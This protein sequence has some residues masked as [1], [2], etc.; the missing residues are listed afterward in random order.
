[1]KPVNRRS[2]NGLI[3]TTALAAGLA[4]TS[5]A[6]PAQAQGFDYVT[7]AYEVATKLY[8][9]HKWYECSFGNTC[10]ESEASILAK[11]IISDIKAT[12]YQIRDNDLFKNVDSLLVRADSLFRAGKPGTVEYATEQS[13]IIKDANDYFY[14]FTRAFEA[15]NH[16]DKV[17]VD[18]AYGLLP[19]FLVMAGLADSIGAEVIARGTSSSIDFKWINDKRD[20]TLATLEMVVGAQSLWYQCSAVEPVS[21]AF[22]PTG[23]FAPRKLVRR[24][25]DFQ[26]AYS[27]DCNNNCNVVRAF[28]PTPSRIC[29]TSCSGFSCYIP[30]STGCI[31]T[32]DREVLAD[33]A[34]E[35]ALRMARDPVVRS[36]RAVMELLVKMGSLHNSALLMRQNAGA[37]PGQMSLWNL[38]SNTSYRETKLRVVP[39]VWQPVVTGDFNGDSYDDVLWANKTEGVMSLWN[40][41]DMQQTAYP[42]VE[43]GTL[44]S[45]MYTINTHT[46]KIFSGDLD[47]DKVSDVVF[48][49]KTVDP[50]L[51]TRSW[52]VTWF[53]QPGTVVPRATSTS[54]TSTDIVQGLGNFDNDLGRQDDVLFRAANGTVLIA[55]NGGAKAAVVGIGAPSLDWVIKGVGDYNGDKKADILWYHVPTGQ[56]SIWF[57]NGRTFLSGPAVTT[58]APSSGWRVQGPADIDHDGLSD[59]VWQIAGARELFNGPISVWLMNNNATIRESTYQTVPAGTELMG[60]LR[61]GPA[62]PANTPRAPISEIYCGYGTGMMRNPGFSGY[63]TWQ[64][65]ST[66]DGGKGILTGDFNGDGRA[67]LVT[68]STTAVT[69][70]S[71]SGGAF[72]APR[73][74]WAQP[75]YGSRGTFAGDANGDAIDDLIGIGETYVG[76][77]QGGVYRTMLST[78]FFGSRGTL[79][80]DVDGD[81]KVDVVAVNANDIQLRRSAGVTLGAATQASA[82]STWAPLTFLVDVD[83]DKRADIVHVDGAQLW[84]RRSL[85]TT[86]GNLE[87]WVPPS[88]FTS[89]TH[90][91]SMA[92]VDGDGRADVVRS[93]DTVVS[94]FR[95]TGKGFASE[96]VWWSGGGF[97]GSHG[98]F[99]ADFDGNGR[100]DLVGVGDGYIGAIRAQ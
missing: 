100:A 68:L 53:M 33:K 58:V 56:V 19:V 91:A 82:I 40:M 94:V 13:L 18:S 1:M 26:F 69:S 32:L 21:S 44:P 46:S 60:F 72:A 39:S 22:S 42:Q 65:G 4:A 55:L 17:A 16:T 66:F 15:T 86:F 54:A 57:M 59:I 77:W 63:E 87:N 20:K 49:T 38:W 45:F 7:K 25:A 50:L 52:Y 47:G 80:G 43:W 3:L 95:S 30:S 75:F 92:D 88:G 51:G 24:F 81:G 29:Y 48:S 34:D 73:T 71:L 90:G 89:G 79:V 70:V 85:G 97:Y 84:V 64:A 67:E 10:Q 98:N 78:A 93:T 6:P 5:V 2:R 28:D 41:S 99:L 9:F 23:A 74:M 83:G 27:S 96:E 12:Q 14:A 31:G 76:L 62:A 37:T 36:A 8:A 61:Q 35:I 11:Q